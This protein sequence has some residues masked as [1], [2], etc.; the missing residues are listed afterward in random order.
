MRP[1]DGAEAAHYVSFRMR[2]AGYRGPDVFSGGAIALIARASGGLTRRINILSDKALLAAFSAGTHAVTE[3]QARA[4]IA[5]S[6]FA[7]IWR[8]RR[9]F[10]AL[11]LVAISG[12]LLG[13]GAYWLLAPREAPVPV[14]TAPVAAAPP[15]AA[16]P[17]AA[18]A[19]QPEA[20]PPTPPPQSPAPV[21]RL[22]RE[23]ILRLAGYAPG[24]NPLLSASLASA[25]ERL[26]TEPDEHYSIELYLS[27]NSSPARVERF[28]MRARELLPLENMLMVPLESGGRYRV[29][30]L[31][32]VYPNRQAALDAAAELPPRYLEAFRTSPR[33]FAELRRAL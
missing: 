4:A 2:A 24:R 29:W 18:P 23:Q 28:L 7:P 22:E 32:G 17:P 30:A 5:D 9:S 10:G 26:D 14:P 12:A 8:A 27:D 1:L 6:E 3:T 13:A 16:P 31:Y 25:R 21:S 15:P 33:S 11:G 20:T 19:P